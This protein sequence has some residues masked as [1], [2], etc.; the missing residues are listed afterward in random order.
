MY[1][2]T[3]NIAFND[4]RKPIMRGSV[5]MPGDFSGV[6]K[7]KAL[8]QIVFDEKVLLSTVPGWSRRSAKFAGYDVEG[9]LMTEDNALAELANTNND[10]IVA[11]KAELKQFV[12][13]L[14]ED[15]C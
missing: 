11:W 2:A 9:F 13:G 14:F 12:A 8:K 7:C 4:G 15:A 1:I 10:R 3:D 6:E 5:V